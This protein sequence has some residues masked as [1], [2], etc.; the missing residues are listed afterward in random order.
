MEVKVGK[1]CLMRENFGLVSEQEIL[2][3]RPGEFILSYQVWQSQR[4][5][6]GGG[7]MFLGFKIQHPERE[8]CDDWMFTPY[9]MAL[10]SSRENDNKL[11]VFHLFRQYWGEKFKPF[12]F[13]KISVLLIS[14]YIALTHSN[15]LYIY[16]NTTINFVFYLYQ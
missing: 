5:S 4:S 16:L 15:T 10:V 8:P 3:M 9:S 13:K 11:F 12:A 1:R 14:V 6:G 2:G 7:L